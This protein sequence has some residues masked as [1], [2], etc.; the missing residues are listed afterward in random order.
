MKPPKP[1]S[2][3]HAAKAKA[4]DPKLWRIVEGA[5]RQTIHDHPDRFV[6]GNL[7]DTIASITK[8]VV[9]A[10]SSAG[11]SAGVAASGAATKDGQGR[12]EPCPSHPIEWPFPT[13]PSDVPVQRMPVCGCPMPAVCFNAACPDGLKVT[14]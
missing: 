5:V 4:R 13:L 3:R 8:R 11:Y 1:L 7:H 10:V 9:G 12:Q 14:C 6:R 2:P